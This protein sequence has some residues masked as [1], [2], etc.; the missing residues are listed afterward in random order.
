MKASKV[1]RLNLGCGTDHRDGFVNIDVD[2]RVKPDV[3]HDL[4][5]PLPF[6][7][8]SVSEIILQDVLE[9]FTKEDGTIL[10][11]ECARVMKPHGMLRIRVPNL[12]QI[13]KQY[14]NYDDV[15]MLFAYGDT[16]TNGVWGAHK[17]GY[18]PEIME[19]VLLQH[20]LKLLQS[21]EVDTNHIY[22]AVKLAKPPQLNIKSE[23]LH[24]T[25]AEL[26]Q[27]KAALP[28]RKYNLYS[29]LSE[30]MWKTIFTKNDQSLT[31][32]YLPVPP[33]PLIGKT[34]LRFLAKRVKAIIVKNDQG[35]EYVRQILKYSHL[36]IIVLR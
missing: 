33:T 21:D 23:T 9:H 36:R 20:G 12:L 8:A 25:K 15:L 24:F 17:Y 35:Y 19:D 30:Q 27:I 3:I 10:L 34:V 18:T 16:S 11:S 29:S 28:P 4:L 13:V 6:A 14:H 26:Q 5:K 7:N 31:L 2:K 22:V 1:L 32:W